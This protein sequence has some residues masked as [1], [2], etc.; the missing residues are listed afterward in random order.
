MKVYVAGKWEDKA[1]VSAVQ[2]LLR[3]QGH[4]I[5]YDWVQNEDPVSAVQAMNDLHGVMKADALVFVAY[6]DLGFRGAYVEM[7]MALALGK[8]VYLRGHGADRCIFTKLPQVHYG[9]DP[10][11]RDAGQSDSL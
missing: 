9:I 4:T 2:N 7:G 3:A 5:T 6:E 1:R 8:P 10:L 11:L